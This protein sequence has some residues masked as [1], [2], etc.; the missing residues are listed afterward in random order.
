MISRA[1]LPE[2]VEPE[3]MAAL[4]R[5]MTSEAEER[6]GEAISLDLFVLASARSSGTGS[7]SAQVDSS[8]RWKTFDW[9]RILLWERLVMQGNRW[10]SPQIPWCPDVMRPVQRGSEAAKLLPTRE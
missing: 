7:G 5:I 3:S 4:R 6:L 1:P 9:A 8:V 10:H 2:R